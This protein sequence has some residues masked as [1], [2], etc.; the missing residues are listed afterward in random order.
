MESPEDQDVRKDQK[1]VPAPADG[2]QHD[3]EDPSSGRRMAALAG[4]PEEDAAD[5]GAEC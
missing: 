5:Q 4:Y 1:I 3:R 2:L